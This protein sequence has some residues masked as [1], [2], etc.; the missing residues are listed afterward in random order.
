MPLFFRG[1]DHPLFVNQRKWTILLV[2]L[3][4]R[5]FIRPFWPLFVRFLLLLGAI[6][7]RDLGFRQQILGHHSVIMVPPALDSLTAGFQPGRNRN[8]KAPPQRQVLK[9]LL[10]LLFIFDLIQ[11][12]RKLPE[13]WGVHQ[14][15]LSFFHH[16]LVEI[17]SFPHTLRRRDVVGDGDEAGDLGSCGCIVVVCVVPRRS[18]T[19]HE[20]TSNR[21]D[22]RRKLLA[23][24]HRSEIRIILDRIIK[25]ARS[26]ATS[27]YLLISVL[28]I[29][30]AE[31]IRR[32]HHFHIRLCPIYFFFHPIDT[33]WRRS[34]ELI[35]LRF[36]QRIFQSL[37]FLVRRPD[38]PS[39][40]TRLT[41]VTRRISDDLR[42]PSLR[43]HL[44][45]HPSLIP[46]NLFT[47]KNDQL[48]VF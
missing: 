10:E 38:N 14:D 46:S 1:V 44:L 36:D 28:I 9:P 21:I 40:N 23:D 3:E 48:I 4:I 13:I 26:R 32:P 43:N 35:S 18:Y 31:W 11:V 29:Q 45:H 34:R 17:E 16:I 12:V 22:G 20:P 19:S 47:A 33:F 8:F 25:G 15:V 24:S 39:L 5:R 42:R 30:R 2:C 37:I 6:G 41:N 7:Q 27:I